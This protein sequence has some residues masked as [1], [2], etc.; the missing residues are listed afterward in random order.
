MKRSAWLKIAIFATGISGLTSEFILSTL[1][2]YFIGDSIV[3]WTVVLS[4]MLFAMGIGSQVSRVVTKKLLLA[5]IAIEFSLSLLI[6]FSPLM[7]YALATKTQ[8]I[9]IIIYCLALLIGFCIGFE[10]PLATRLN[11]K[12]ESLNK[13]ISNIMSWD[14]I[15]SLVGGIAFAYIG[16]PYLGITNTA[17]LFGALNFVV[18]VILFWKYKSFYKKQIKWVTLSTLLIVTTLTSGFIFSEDIILFGEQSRYKDKIIYTEQS[19]YQKIV[20]TQWHDHYWL[21]INNNQQLSTL[22]E[23]LYH[24]PM[25]HPIM[26]ITPEHQD[27]L[28]IGGGDGF[29]VKELLKYEGIKSID[30]VDLDPAMTNLGLHFKPLLEY[31]DSSLHNKIVKIHNVDGYNFLEKSK[32]YYDLIIVDLPDA[33]GI[34][35]N[36]LYT[37]EFYRMAYQSLR[38]NGNII[39]QAGSPYYATKA[40]YCIEKTMKSSNFNTLK[41][42]NQVLTLGEWGW[43]IGSK[44]LKDDEM[45]KIMKKASFEDLNTKW[46]NQE[47]IDLITS[48]GKPIFDTTGVEVNTINDPVLYRYYIQGNWDL[49]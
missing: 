16:L 18:A 10:I 9:H 31:N 12:H 38:P 22:D 19:R 28:I 6:S 44:K 47:S 41:I 37:Q 40:Y 34:D 43:V 36:K 42:H 32:K 24:E 27:I 30:V 5:F 26:T 3:Q 8:F 25:I 39:T 4:I 33:K 17:F 21:F 23:Y 45:I 14:Y 13:N 2:S 29:N 11:E 49:Y 20:V 7:V 1:A 35:I 15:G 46:L 48:F